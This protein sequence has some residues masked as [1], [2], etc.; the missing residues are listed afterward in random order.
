MMQNFSNSMELA[1]PILVNFVLRKISA[2]RRITPHKDEIFLENF[3]D[4]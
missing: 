2:Y 3:F 1:I 4:I